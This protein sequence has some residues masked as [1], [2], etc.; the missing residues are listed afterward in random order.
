MRTVVCLIIFLAT[1]PIVHAFTLPSEESGNHD[2]W[3]KDKW[4][5]RGELNQQ[6]YNHCMQRAHEGYLSVVSLAQS[7]ANQAWI[8]DAINDAVK[9]WT[10]RGM[11]PDDM[12]HF[13]LKT[14]TEGYEDL[15]YMAKQP[16]WNKG[17]YQA[18]A[19]KWGIKYNMVVVCYKD[20]QIK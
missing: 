11:R 14:I 6:M 8:Q 19:Q 13:A 17:K 20:Y 15:T 1:I 9:E 18:C 10:N 12:V 16:G 2:G 7:Y 4:T 3:C 5:K